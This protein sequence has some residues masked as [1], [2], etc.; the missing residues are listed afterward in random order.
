MR[1]STALSE[2]AIGL[3]EHF[4]AC[5]QDILRPVKTMIGDSFPI[6]KREKISSHYDESVAREYD[7]VC[8]RANSLLYEQRNLVQSKW[9]PRFDI[10]RSKHSG[11]EAWEE[12]RG[13]LVD[14]CLDRLCELLVAN[15]PLF[16]NKDYVEQLQA[17]VEKA[18][19]A[20]KSRMTTY[21][22]GFSVRRRPGYAPLNE[23]YE[24]EG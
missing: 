15:S 22:Q 17:A 23:L 13:C 11:G 18:T 10:S 6:E 7:K 19:E 14:N 9:L 8:K 3:K 2:T 4:F 16:V 24:I 20:A 12:L 5:G 1:T 21:L